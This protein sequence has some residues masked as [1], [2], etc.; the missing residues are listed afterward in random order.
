[1]VELARLNHE[2]TG[3]LLASGRIFVDAGCFLDDYTGWGLVAIDQTNS[4]V[5]SACRKEGIVTDP[6][7]AEALGVRW[8]LQMAK[9]LHWNTVTVLSDS[10]VVVNCVN[11]KYV[12]AAID[13]IIQDCQELMVELARSQVVYVNRSLN[14]IAHSL[15]KLSKNVGCST[16]LGHV[17]SQANIHS[18]VTSIFI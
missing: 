17:P 18:F 11:S 13:H 2:I 8:G 3:K 14:S 15:V 4:V 6:T 1:V 12:V 7:L 5:L 16:W 10:E 9:Q